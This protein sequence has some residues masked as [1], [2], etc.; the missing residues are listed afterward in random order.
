MLFFLGK[1]TKHL[2]EYVRAFVLLLE[3]VQDPNVH[4]YERFLHQV[5]SVYKKVE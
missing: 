1:A 4:G 2:N 5:I 3:K